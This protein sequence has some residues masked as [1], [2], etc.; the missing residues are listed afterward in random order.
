MRLK[1][2]S[3]SDP[4]RSSRLEMKGKGEVAVGNSADM[5]LFDENWELQD[6]YSKGVLMMKNNEL[7]QKG[8]FEY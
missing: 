3:S 4:Q 7:L 5:C 1:K 8:T 2:F 6:V